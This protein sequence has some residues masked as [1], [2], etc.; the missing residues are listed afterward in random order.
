ML[1]WNKLKPYKT[2]KEKSFEQLCFQIAMRLYEIEGN[3]TPIDDSGGGDGV[4]FYITLPS[5]EQ[6]GWQTKFY[7]GNVRLRDSNRKQAI[8]GSLKKTLQVHPN[9]TKWFLCLPL[10]PTTDETTW[11]KNE[12]SKEIPLNRTVKIIPWTHTS[13]QSCQ[14]TRIQWY[15][16][17]IF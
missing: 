1:D 6:W 15:L 11:I 4:E 5:G 13:I 9:L 8:K 17:G 16:A 7:E 3:F 10:D 12:L 2:S 14:P